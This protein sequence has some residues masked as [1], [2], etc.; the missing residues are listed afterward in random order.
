MNDAVAAAVNHFEQ[1]IKPLE[2]P[3]GTDSVPFL[4]KGIPATSIGMMDRELGIEGFHRP[5]DN[6][7]RVVIERM[8]ETENI[9][10]HILAE[11]D[12]GSLAVGK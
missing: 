11:Y 12:S 3:V 2:G 5:A 4:A 1:E 8:P 10:A 6:L 7:E 9:V